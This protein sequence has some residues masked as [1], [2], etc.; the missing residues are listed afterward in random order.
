M[1]CLAL[2]GVASAIARSRALKAKIILCAYMASVDYR[3][4]HSR[5]NGFTILVNSRNDR[6]TGGYTAVDY[7][8]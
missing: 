5:C 6:E 4:Q 8:R 3:V 7:I 2:R 1:P